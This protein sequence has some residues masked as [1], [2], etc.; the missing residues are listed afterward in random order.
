VQSNEA[1]ADARRLS[2]SPLALEK[3]GIGWD[4]LGAASGGILGTL[5]RSLVRP[6]ALS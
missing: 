4:Q 6:G 5:A 3:A 2:Q 1:A